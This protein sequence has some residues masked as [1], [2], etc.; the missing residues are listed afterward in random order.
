[1]HPE[2]PA[3]RVY[4]ACGFVERGLR[5]NYRLMVAQRAA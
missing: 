4:E 5:R 2:N 1:V 3:I